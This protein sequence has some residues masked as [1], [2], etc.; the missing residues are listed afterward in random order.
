VRLFVSEYVIDEIRAL[1]GKIPAKYAVTQAQINELADQVSLFGI[2]VVS[3]PSVYTHST[4]PADSHYVDLAAATDSSL[5]VSRDRHLL[6]LMDE[7]RDDAKDFR[8]RF[9]Q[10]LI[11]TPDVFARTLR[12]EEGSRTPV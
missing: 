7:K 11:V 10:I 1:D 3:V 2:F 4:D 8:L 9:P 6:N 5:I 12:D